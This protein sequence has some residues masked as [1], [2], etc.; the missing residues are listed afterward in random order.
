MNAR[1]AL[2][3]LAG[4]LLTPAWADESQPAGTAPAASAQRRPSP[5]GAEVAIVNIKDGATVATTFLVQFSVSGMSIAPAGTDL[6]NTGH[7]HLLIDVEELPDPN[8]PLPKNE[9]F[10]HF[11]GGQTEVELTLSPGV[12]TLQLVFADY[13]HVPH[14]PVVKS[15]PITVTVV[16]DPKAVQTG[17]DKKQ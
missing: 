9:H 16:Q 17:Q 6:P 11:G 3:F 12:H 7:H 10:M 15:V 4:L 13:A 8:L 1:F 5:P 2:F 14:N